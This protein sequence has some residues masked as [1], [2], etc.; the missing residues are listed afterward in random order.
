MNPLLQSERRERDK[1]KV[2]QLR[3]R[4]FFDVLGGSRDERAEI[5]REKNRA[6]SGAEW[7]RI[8]PHDREGSH[9]AGGFLLVD[10]D[11]ERVWSKPSSLDHGAHAEERTTPDGG[12]CCLSASGSLRAQG[13]PARERQCVV[14][15][16]LVSLLLY[17]SL[18]H[19]GNAATNS[20]VS[21]KRIKLSGQNS[22]G[23]APN[24]IYK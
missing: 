21:Q 14:A 1:G 3:V 23:R 2:A 8:S 18:V 16:S 11:R 5:N 9:R 12:G 4:S 19:R 10:A 17:G 6:P 15:F 24:K 20:E 22:V 7:P 13:S